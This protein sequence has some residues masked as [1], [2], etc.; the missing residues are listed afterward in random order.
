MRRD[1]Q[2]G[3]MHTIASTAAI[4]EKGVKGSLESIRLA[5]KI[6]GRFR[7][8][9]ID[10]ASRAPALISDDSM[11]ITRLLAADRSTIMSLDPGGKDESLNP[12]GAA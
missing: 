5:L 11:S 2:F 6:G 1:E 12:E 3:H 4:C 8:E 7:Q 9:E 10:A